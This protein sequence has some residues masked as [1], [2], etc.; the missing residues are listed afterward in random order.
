MGPHL[1]IQLLGAFRASY[2]DDLLETLTSP[3]LQSLLAY[4]LLHRGAPQ[5]RQYVSF[6]FWPDS[7]ESQARTNLRKLLHDLRRALPDP[8]TFLRADD[9]TLSWQDDAPLTLDVAAFEAALVEAKEAAQPGT[10]LARA[11]ELYVGDL[12]P[13]FYADWIVPERERLRERYS[14]ALEQLTQLLEEQGD[15][16]RA[17]EYASLL[18]RHDPLH[19][20]GYRRLMRLHAAQGDRAGALQVYQRC[21]TVLEE[22]LGVEPLPETQAVYEAVLQGRRQPAAAPAAAEA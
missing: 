3:R 9:Q 20:P 17:T 6:L 11:V 21:V 10:A 18:L 12:L 8:D 14:G 5:P 7:T 22:E 1:H 19:E 16:S 4:L 2:G 15:L 13:S